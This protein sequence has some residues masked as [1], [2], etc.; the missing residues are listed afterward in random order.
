MD[1]EQKLIRLELTL[2]LDP[3]RQEDLTQA[4]IELNAGLPPEKWEALLQLSRAVVSQAES[5]SVH[6]QLPPTL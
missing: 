3:S 2:Q 6:L 4:A 5:L 1:Q